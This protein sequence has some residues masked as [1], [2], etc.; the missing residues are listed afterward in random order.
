MDRR[1][2]PRISVQLPVAVWGLDAFGQAFTESAMITNMSSGGI[3]LQ[4]LRKRM[5]AGEV[6]DVRMGR[7]TANF[8]VIWVNE[9]GELGME[10]LTEQTFLPPDVLAHCAQLAVC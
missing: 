2:N 5:R 10:A 6:L 7:E 1:K 8:R 4:G 9:K 3:V